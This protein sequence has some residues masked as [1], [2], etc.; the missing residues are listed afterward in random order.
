MPIDKTTG[1]PAYKPAADK[2][3]ADKSAADKS[4]ADKSAADKSAADKSAADKS[5]AGRIDNRD[6]DP[7]HPANKTLSPDREPTQRSSAE[8]FGLSGD[9][10]MTEQEKDADNDSMGVGPLARSES[11]SGPVTTMEDEGIGPRTPYPTGDPPPPAES[12][13]YSQG[14]KGV[15]D[16]PSVKPGA[17]S[18]PAGEAP[19]VD[20]RDKAY[21][22]SPKTDQ[23]H[24]KGPNP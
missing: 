4:A 8:H 17:S 1:K 14:I 24:Q 3:A 20:D 21:K 6:Q 23:P 11:T 7:D 16:K 22:V 10:L 13:S 19:K 15:T 2:S 9:A 18:G 12:I 5:A